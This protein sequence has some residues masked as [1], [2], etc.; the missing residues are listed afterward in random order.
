MQSLL[1]WTTSPPAAQ[2][3]YLVALSHPCSLH[4]NQRCDSNVVQ[5]SIFELAAVG[6][7][8]VAKLQWLD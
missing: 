1:W 7:A 2:Q 3:D 5:L 8:V 4:D 6:S